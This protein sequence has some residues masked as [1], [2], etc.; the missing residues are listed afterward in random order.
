VAATAPPRAV[1]PAPSPPP[2]DPNFVRV[3]IGSATSFMGTTTASVNKVMAPLAAKL[4]ACHRAAIPQTV[5]GTINLHIE[6]DLDGVITQARL[7]GALPPS[8]ASCI[9]N[10]V[11]G[12]KI[13]NVDTGIATA[14]VP[15]SFKTR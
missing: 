12:R 3:E 5:E 6:T 11:H 10:A 13:P 15:L 14:D 2:L 4:S 7:G 1:A 9:V 8:I